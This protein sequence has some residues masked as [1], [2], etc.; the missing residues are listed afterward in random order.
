MDSLDGGL[1]I[2]IGIAQ[3]DRQIGD[4][5]LLR[6]WVVL[7]LR[8]QRWTKAPSGEAEPNFRQTLVFVGRTRADSGTFQVLPEFLQVE[9]FAKLRNAIWKAAEAQVDMPIAGAVSL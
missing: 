2:S 5:L 6:R 9:A 4:G 7:R 8:Q 1:A 3:E